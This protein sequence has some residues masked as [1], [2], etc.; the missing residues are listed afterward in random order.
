MSQLLTSP[1]LLSSSPKDKGHAENAFGTLMS[2]A[3]IYSN[4][5]K[6]GIVPF[7][8][9]IVECIDGKKNP[10][11]GWCHGRR[12]CASPDAALGG[13][14]KADTSIMDMMQRLKTLQ[15]T[16]GSKSSEP[17]KGANVLTLLQSTVAI[18]KS[19]R[20]RTQSA[21]TSTNIRAPRPA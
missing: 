9:G 15:E 19:R 20:W 10:R 14:F 4:L 6:H 18:P 1:Q 21:V 5:T 16:G 11:L 2:L 3:S 8:K 17:P 7:Y 12:A 13:V